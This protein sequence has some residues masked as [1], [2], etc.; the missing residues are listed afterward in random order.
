MTEQAT[1]RKIKI[2]YDQFYR[3][4]R[5]LD[6]VEQMKQD[7]RIKT[8]AELVP[9]DVKS[10]LFI[11]CGSGWEM[12][13]AVGKELCI[14]L[15]I[16]IWALKRAKSHW[17]NCHFVVGDAYNLLFKSRSFDLIV[18]SEVI[19]HLATPGAAVSEMVRVLHTKGTGI[20]SCPNMLSLFGFFRAIAE[21]IL[22]R[23]V[24]AGD[25]LID[26][27]F[28]PRTLKELVQHH[29]VISTT[30]GY[31]YFPPNGKGRIKV[32]GKIVSSILKVLLPIDRS[33]GI[34]LPYLGHGIVVKVLPKQNMN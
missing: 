14:G 9:S 18:C 10:S 22:R 8:I 7:A 16:S 12:S 23:E 5:F 28:T 29:F 26:H 30:R 21:F 11:G 31:W 27:W 17:N 20:I 15:D 4:P 13:T 3:P 2:W 32:S 19:E 6:D 25:Q 34:H 33:F 24:T 1:L